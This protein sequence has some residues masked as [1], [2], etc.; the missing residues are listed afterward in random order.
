[1]GDSLASKALLALLGAVT[2]LFAK[3]WFEAWQ[4]YRTW[5]LL[6]AKPVYSGDGWVLQIENGSDLPI[7]AA[8]AYLSI[9]IEDTDFAQNRM[10]EL[11]DPDEVPLK[12]WPITP[13]ILKGPL[14]ELSTHWRR[15]VGGY[16]KPEGALATLCPGEVQSLKLVR[17]LQAAL[18]DGS[19]GESE[20]IL[21]VSFDA[22]FSDEWVVLVA[23]EKGFLEPM[24]CLHR[25]RYMARLKVVSEGLPAKVFE[26]EINPDNSEMLRVLRVAPR[27]NW[28]DRWEAQAKG[29]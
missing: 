29:E 12:F 24:A 4:R 1:M 26:L 2:A 16:D 6:S 9:Q 28:I 22:E 13:R 20:S 11:A 18:C 15:G 21:S 5:H 23:S 19:T 8:A 25:K 3:V 14:E 7:K 10:V 17:L 27:P